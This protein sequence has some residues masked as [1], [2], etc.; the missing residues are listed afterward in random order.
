MVVLHVPPIQQ[1]G[2]ASWPLASLL[3]LRPARR[4]SLPKTKLTGAPLPIPTGLTWLRWPH[5]G[6]VLAMASVLQGAARSHG[7]EP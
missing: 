7:F 4:T 3:L 6:R 1:G 5:H 2:V